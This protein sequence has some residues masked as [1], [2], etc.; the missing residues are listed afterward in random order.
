M[1]FMISLLICYYEIENSKYF[2]SQHPSDTPRSSIYSPSCAKAI[3]SS[4]NF[5]GHW[6]VR[7]LAAFLVVFLGLVHDGI[8][9][10]DDSHYGLS[11]LGNSRF[12]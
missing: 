3:S 9:V 10:L 5:H 2:L 12:G 6:C 4:S 1:R 7:L 11:M 8:K